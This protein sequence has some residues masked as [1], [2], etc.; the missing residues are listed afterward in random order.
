MV[1]YDGLIKHLVKETYLNNNE[2]NAE[3][4]SNVILQGFLQMKP[5]LTSPHIN[6]IFLICSN[7]FFLTMSMNLV[8]LWLPQIF[9]VTSDHQISES[10]NNTD[11]CS[12]FEELKNANIS[13]DDGCTVNLDNTSVYVNSIIVGTAGVITFCL[14]G[15][16]VN[17]LGKKTLTILFSFASGCFCCSVYFSP[18]SLIMM[19]LYSMDVSLGCIADNVLTTITLELF[20]TAL[21]TSALCLHLMFGRFGTVVGNII[22]PHLLQIGCAPPVFFLGCLIFV[23]LTLTT[24]YPST[25]N[26]PLL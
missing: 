26:K 8:K 6:R 20:P 14:A 1:I 24:F 5:F 23:S 13:V 21:R 3:K 10:S 25:E 16:L 22:L 17:L 18:N 2:V 4:S 12:I 19:I 9:Q 15:T 7:T 11:V